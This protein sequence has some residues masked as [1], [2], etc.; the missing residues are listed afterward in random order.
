MHSLAP[1]S[2]NLEPFSTATLPELC[3]IALTSK[4]EADS[5]CSIHPA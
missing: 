4:A 5:T 2:N 3:G 1:G